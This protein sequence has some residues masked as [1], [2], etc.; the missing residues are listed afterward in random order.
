MTI[1]PSFTGLQDQIFKVTLDVPA[2]KRPRIISELQNNY[3][4]IGFVSGS[5]TSIDISTKEMNKAVGLEYLS[6]KYHINPREMVAFGDSGN[7]VGMLK[8]VG[9]SYVTATA[10]PIAKSAANRVIGSSNSSAVQKEIWR[11]LND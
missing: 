8:Y 3:P 1:V 4:Q 9:Q 5:A 7:D 6:K 10:L 2:K 11:L